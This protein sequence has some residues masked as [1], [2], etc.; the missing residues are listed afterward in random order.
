M[1]SAADPGRV[2]HSAPRRTAGTRLSRPHRDGVPGDVH[3]VTRWVGQ[4]APRELQAGEALPGAVRRSMEEHLGADFSGVRVHHDERAAAVAETVAAKAFT[5][6]DDIVFGEG[7][8]DPDTRQGRWLLAHELAHVVQQSRGGPAPALDR[9]SPLELEARSAADAVMTGAGPPVIAGAASPG[10]AR[11]EEDDAPNKKAPK[12]KAKKQEPKPEPGP[13]SPERKEQLLEAARAANKNVV[14]WEPP[15][16]DPEVLKAVESWDRFDLETEKPTGI[17]PPLEER[18]PVPPGE[19]ISS[20]PRLTE[21][22]EDPH[23]RSLQDAVVAARGF[24]DSIPVWAYDEARARL[25]AKRAELAENPNVAAD[26]ARLKELRDK[27]APLLEQRDALAR[28][29]KELRARRIEVGKQP[30]SAARDAE[31]QQIAKDLAEVAASAKSIRAQIKPMTDEMTPLLTTERQSQA[32]NA[33]QRKLAVSGLVDV[34]DPTKPSPG[35]VIG[36]GQNT[37]VVMQVIDAEGTVLAS[38]LARNGGWDKTNNRLFHAEENAIR[39]LE[40][41][42]GGREVPGG[43]V[44]VVGDQVVCDKICEPAVRKFASEKVKAARADGYTFHGKQPGAADS[45]ASS[46]KTTAQRSTEARLGTENGQVVRLERADE[47]VRQQ[48][49]I[50]RAPDEEPSPGG[51]GGGGKK[52]AATGTTG[53][54]PS[55]PSGTPGAKAGGAA[56]PPPVGTRS[57]AGLAVKP[58][59]GALPAAPVVKPPVAPVPAAPGVEQ[60]VAAPVVKPPVVPAAP[61]VEPP[62]APAPAAPVVKSPAPAAP[63][64]PAAP[65]GKPP[66]APAPQPPAPKPPAPKPP[67]SKPPAPKPPAPKPPSPKMAATPVAQGHDQ[68]V[69]G[70]VK[71]NAV[72]GALLEA[73]VR[74][75]QLVDQG[76]SS[77]S[78]WVE[79]SGRAA[80]TLGGNL[81]GG[82]AGG[83]IDAY[84]AYER[85]VQAGQGRVEAVETAVATVGGSALASR[86]V[87]PSVAGLVV[88]GV[89]TGAQLVGAPE[90]V[91]LATAGA[92]E[93]V[94]GQIIARTGTA[95]VRAAFAIADTIRGD[96]KSIDRLVTDWKKGGGGTWLQGYTQWIDIGVDVATG[97]RTFEQALNKAAKEGE[98]D[99]AGNETW[100]SKVGGK[101]GTGFADLGENEA[102]LRGEYSP[103]VQGLAQLSRLGSEMIRGKD[104]VDA[105]KAVGRASTGGPSY[106]LAEA[107]RRKAV[108]VR[109]AAERAKA[110]AEQKAA[111]V[112]VAVT[113]LTSDAKATATAWRDQAADTA[114]KLAD[115]AVDG[116]RAAATGARDSVRKFLGW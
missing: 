87:K 114:K 46:P 52:A 111:A 105:L 106:R 99:A 60:P 104:F 33:A 76:E 77:A 1:S 81:K 50:W 26:L 42:L 74:H 16:D 39:D 72:L 18:P 80:L 32:V 38:S 47:L 88:E 66:A 69:G 6:G 43:R 7:R 62:V 86:A 10:V 17:P 49:S 83:A 51:Q 5:L 44:V 4:Q 55:K 109:D 12:K 21:T 82:V 56:V 30:A 75:Q 28:R 108:E 100:A 67:A 68:A 102:A 78:A 15:P 40:R 107:A 103:P 110:R 85:S 73:K 59:A 115:Q 27:R 8:W 57:A 54:A 89:N 63:A 35:A 65:V 116:A 2:A 36:R 19:V 96:P 64:A 91:Q 61:G 93:L 101:L 95:G 45:T 41:Q 37:Y 20:Q 22:G 3:A 31:L 34:D 29:S 84:N 70:L 11:E 48:K 14:K 53:G 58:P 9:A 13:T 90:E 23:L 112:K 94:P 98:R 71:A 92:V 79:A 113:E 25:E 24:A 97:T